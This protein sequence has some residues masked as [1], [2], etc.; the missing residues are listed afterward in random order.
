MRQRELKKLKAMLAKL[1]FGQRRDLLEALAE[2]SGAAASVGIIEQA[3]NHRHCPHCTSEHTV[4]NGSASGL[5]RYK[6]RGCGRTFNAL[7]GTALARLR[8]K[9]KWLTQAE[10]LRCEESRP[11]FSLSATSGTNAGI[12]ATNCL[13]EIRTIW[14]RSSQLPLL[15]YGWFQGQGRFRLAKSRHRKPPAPC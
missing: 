4:R 5:Q 1:T 13:T 11:L 2:E 10:V 14:R 8:Q 3:E 12:V 9:S 6:C 15:P 7:T